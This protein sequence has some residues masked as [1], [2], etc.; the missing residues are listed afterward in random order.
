MWDE[1]TVANAL[2]LHEAGMNACEISRRTGLPRA[3]VR[4]WLGG[5]VPARRRRP[6]V[7]VGEVPPDSYRS[8]WNIEISRREAVAALDEFV[9]PKR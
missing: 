5:K 8:R 1:A 2:R 6:F 4:D 7:D 3:T 9:G